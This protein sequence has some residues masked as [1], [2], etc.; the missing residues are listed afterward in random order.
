MKHSKRILVSIIAVAGIIYFL[1]V[2]DF[3]ARQEEKNTQPVNNTIK[4]TNLDTGIHVGKLAPDFTLKGLDGKE[5]RLEDFKG[6]KVMVNFWASWCPPC[7]NEMPDMQRFYEDK[8]I[9]ILA[10]NLTDTERKAEDVQQFAKEY[11]LSFPILLDK[12][13]KV[14]ENYQIKPIPTT[15][16][17]DSKGYIH[18]KAFGAMSYELMIQEFEKMK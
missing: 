15:Y 14:S 5:Y 18:Y 3:S 1:S 11:K 7:R 13:G 6:K 8:D 17:I 10:V 2:S 9:V 16:L 12:D 4:P